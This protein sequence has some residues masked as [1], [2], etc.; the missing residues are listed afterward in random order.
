MAETKDEAL[1]KQI[2]EDFRYSKEYWRENHEESEKDMDCIAC[3]PPAE[4]TADRA[5]RPCIW[6]DEI[7]QYVKQSNNN[8][9]QNKRSIKISPRS[10]DATDQDAEHRQAYIRGI[11]YA[12]Q[13]QSVYS[14][15]FEACV[16][17][18]FGFWRV[19]T[20]VTGPNGEQEPRIKR[21]PNQFTVYPD[22]DAMESDFSDSNTYFVVDTLR[23]STFAARYP[24]AQKRSFSKEDIDI[25]PGWFHGENIVIAEA[26]TRK[27]IS[28]GKHEVTQRITNGVEILETNKWLGSWIP[29][30]G[31][32]GE[33]IY[34]RKGGQSK[35]MFMSLVRRMRAPQQ[36]LAYVASQEME[37]FQMAPRAPFIV[38]KGT[39]DPER[40]KNAHKVPVAYLEYK[41]PTDWNPQW[42]A[43]PRP[44]R[45]QFTP[46]I[47]AYEAAY[48][49]IR[50]SI[51]AAAGITP[52]PTAAQRQNEKS[53]VALEKIQTQE[54]IGSFHF[55][56]NFSRSL[57]NTGR[58]VNE[59]ITKLAESDSLPA[60]LLGKDQKDED[61][62][63][64]VA[65]SKT[66]RSPESEH[67][68]EADQFFAHIGVFEETVSDGPNYLSER[69]EASAFSD[70]LLENLPHMGLPP[71]INQEM[72]AIAVKLKNIGVF[73][74]EISDLLSPPDPNKLTPQAKAILA[75]AQGQVQELQ[76]QIQI[77]ML[78]KLGKVTETKGKMALS[79]QEHTFN[80][81]E[82]DKDRETKLAVAEI[83]TKAQNINERIAAVEDLMKQ[84]HDQAHDLAM[85][86]VTHAQAKELADKQAAAQSAQSSQ[87]AGQQ[88][89]Q[90]AQDHVQTSAQ[91][92]QAAEQQPSE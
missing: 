46:N 50:R 43:P 68:D 13:A 73:G 9:R 76:K 90:S 80:M 58:Q 2:R 44:E 6:P 69:E 38:V 3:I 82:A 39:V 10:E 33:E 48:E 23:Q 42:G 29:I 7:S 78:E 72:L 64:K 30:I 22:P 61:V 70:T 19:T 18:A 21:I 45:P 25:A 56:D 35:R 41:M 1:L 40:W 77:L 34:V 54:A 27:E 79:E 74:D 28:E 16:E 14:T 85:T 15:A 89:A 62:K 65:S 32:F 81:T 87:E 12:S 83:T 17:S 91:Q 84:F 67:L 4:F 51:Q 8:L 66:Q 53:G 60:Q 36:M 52:L 31:M 11:E 75:Q 55:T 5:G 26:W 88:S 63:I 49:R 20:K 24:K 47:E 59:L 86:N 37:E 92:Q 71:Q 57:A